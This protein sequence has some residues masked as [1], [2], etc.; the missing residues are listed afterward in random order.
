MQDLGPL[1]I[2]QRGPQTRG[3][4]FARTCSQ[5]RTHIEGAVHIVGGQRRLTR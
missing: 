2:K 3:Q 4:R 1:W 5:H